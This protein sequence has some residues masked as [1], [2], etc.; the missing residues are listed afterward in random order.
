MLNSIL[1][2]L[3]EKS[4]YVSSK[5]LPARDC[6]VLRCERFVSDRRVSI[7][8]SSS[9]VIVAPKSDHC[10][11][12]GWPLVGPCVQNGHFPYGKAVAINSHPAPTLSIG[13]S[14]WDFWE[15]WFEQPLSEWFE[16]KIHRGKNQEPKLRQ[17]FSI[18]VVLSEISCTYYSWELQTL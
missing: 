4:L 10:K 5:Y 2:K 12:V 1:W 6:D 3:L 17:W 9:N 15:D 14:A 18:T 7:T 13:Y 16:F 11:H 8:C